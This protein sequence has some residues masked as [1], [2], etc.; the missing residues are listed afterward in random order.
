[1]SVSTIGDLTFSLIA[2]LF[3]GRFHPLEIVLFFIASLLS[4]AIM[5]AFS[6]LAGSLAFFMGSA[7]QV[8]GM[9][10][11][12][13]LTF[14]IYPNTIFSGISRFILYTLIPA[15]FVGAVP[16]E[17]IKERSLPL[18]AMLAGVTIFAW[19]LAAAVFY[20]GLRRYESGSAI[21]L[22]R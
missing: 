18:L 16:V 15:A 8:S 12:A 3:T 10:N 22:N 11:N 13:I 21:N 14:S 5:V 7:S 19:L 9:L 2:Y 17:I 20:A 6:T 1:M 4:G